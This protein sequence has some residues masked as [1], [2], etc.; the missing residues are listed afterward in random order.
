MLYLPLSPRLGVRELGFQA[1]LVDI[2]SGLGSGVD[3][4]SACSKDGR[5]GR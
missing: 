5:R 3:G 2:S 1:G 4:I